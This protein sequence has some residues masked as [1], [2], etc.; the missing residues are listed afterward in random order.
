M[1]RKP[2]VAKNIT[3]RLSLDPKSYQKIKSQM[4]NIDKVLRKEA[5]NTA[6]L[7][8]GVILRDEAAARAPGPHIIMKLI[9]GRTLKGKRYR[10]LGAKKAV[11]N[12]SR[13]VA[14]GP[15]YDHWYYRFFEFGATAHDVSVRDPGF[16]A[17]EN[18]V[19]AF[20]KRSGGTPMRP[21]LRPA[22]DSKGQAAIDAMTSVMNHEIKKAAR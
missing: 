22:I 11:K 20:A 7:A 19:A 6:L 13:F 15:D 8:G 12:N 1:I 9:T 21:F 16:I 5:M 14:I 3:A 2:K 4:Q 17:F 10:S 18:V